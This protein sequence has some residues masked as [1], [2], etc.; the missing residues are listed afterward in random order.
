MSPKR[1]QRQIPLSAK[2]RPLQSARLKFI[3]QPPHFLP[4]TPFPT[5]TSVLFS[6]HDLS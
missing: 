4:A 5:I 6:F 3:N 1:A 2:L